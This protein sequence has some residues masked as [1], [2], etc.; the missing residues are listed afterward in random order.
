MAHAMQTSN[1]IEEYG[2]HEKF[3]PQWLLMYSYF[4]VYKHVTNGFPSNIVQT[5]GIYHA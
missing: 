1:F 4:I 5:N 3:Y 2:W